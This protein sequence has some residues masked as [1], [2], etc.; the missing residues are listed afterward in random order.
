MKQKLKNNKSFLGL[1]LKGIENK[2]CEQC[3]REYPKNVLSQI[4]YSYNIQQK[5]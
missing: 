2:K 4:Y 5:K 1:S 3:R